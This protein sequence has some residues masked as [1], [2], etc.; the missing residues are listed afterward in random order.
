MWINLALSLLPIALKEAPE[1]IADVEKI[2][3][4]FKA[5]NFP[6]AATEAIADAEQIV[7]AVAPGLVPGAQNPVT[8]KPGNP[9]GL[10]PLWILLGIMGSLGLMGCAGVST[11]AFRSEK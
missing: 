11:A 3:A 6:A 2:V 5:K 7:A 8:P 4:D 9:G 10:M 1:I